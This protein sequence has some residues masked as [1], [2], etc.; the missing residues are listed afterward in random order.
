MARNDKAKDSG[1]MDKPSSGSPGRSGF[2]P[3]KWV[4]AYLDE[5]DRQWLGN[6]VH[7]LASFVVEFVDALPEGYTLSTK[8]EH[9]SGK[10]LASLICSD[11]GDGN[12]GYAVS[13][14]GTTRLD[15]IY[16]L[17]YVVGEKLKWSLAASDGS[18]D[19]GRWG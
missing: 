4:N 11:S 1:R 12:S 8:F 15:S 10:Y 17:A 2:I 9:T 6:H 16:A 5:T 13:M 18:G 19:T 7:E 3:V 14:R